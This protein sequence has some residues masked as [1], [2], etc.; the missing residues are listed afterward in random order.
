LEYCHPSIPAGYSFSLKVPLKP[1]LEHVIMRR[2]WVITQESFE[3]LLAWLDPNREAAGQKYENIRVRLIKIFSIRGCSDAEDLADLTINRVIAR[4]P[5]IKSS[6][7][8]DPVGYFHGVARK[9]YLESRRKK[10]IATGLPQS[11]AAPAIGVGVVRECLRECLKQLT[12]DQCELVLEY[13]LNDKRAKID[14]RKH[15]AERFNLTAN[16]LRLRAHRIRAILE[17]CVVLCVNS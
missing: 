9:I 8:G 15:L 13:Y 17:K 7:V 6:Y 1:I 12:A 3:A 16:A 5:D 14:H 11:V 2:E 4:L 10:E